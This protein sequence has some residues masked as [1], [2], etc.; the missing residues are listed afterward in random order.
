MGDE[1]VL[2]CGVALGHEDVTKPENSLITERA[3]LDD[4]AVF[5][6]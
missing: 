6:K 4:W 1:E 3:P 5:L 2:V